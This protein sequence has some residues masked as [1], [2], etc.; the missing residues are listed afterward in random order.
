MGQEVERFYGEIQ[1]LCAA[2]LERWFSL[3]GDASLTL[4]RFTE[5]FGR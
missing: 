1:I 2:D 3:T 5:I 4:L